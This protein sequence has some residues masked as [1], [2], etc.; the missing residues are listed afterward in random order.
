[1]LSKKQL[2]GLNV[3]N[4]FLHLKFLDDLLNQEEDGAAFGV[5]GVGLGAVYTVRLAF[6]MMVLHAVLLQTHRAG[7]MLIT[8]VCV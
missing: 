6:N 7:W 3:S 5:G 2:L 8:A 1:L 4:A